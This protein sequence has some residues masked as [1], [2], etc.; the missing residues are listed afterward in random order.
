VEVTARRGEDG[1]AFG[2]RDDGAG[3][4]TDVRERLSGRRVG[5]ERGFG[6]RLCQEIAA[7]LGV[8]IE[9]LAPHGGGTE[10]RVTLPAEAPAVTEAKR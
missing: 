6:L 5:E 9:A 10:I 4:P 8:R 7:T 1:V 2:V 3:L